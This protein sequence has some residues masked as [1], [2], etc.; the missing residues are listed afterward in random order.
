[1]ANRY[2]T[3]GAILDSINEWLAQQNFA[4]DVLLAFGTDSDQVM[5]N[6]SGS[7]GGDTALANVLIGTPVTPSIAA[8]TL[9]ISNTTASGD[10]LMAGNRGGN[11]EAFLF[12]DSN[13]GVLYL[14][15]VA[16]GLTVGLAADAPTAD[17][18]NVHLWNG[19]AGSVTANVNSVLV[20]E[21]SAE[22]AISMLG[23]NNEAKIIYFG[24]ASDND[25]AFIGYRGS[26]DTPANTLF[27]GTAASQ[28]LLY[29]ANA[30]AFQ[31][32]T[33]ISTTTGN[34]S[35]A[36]TGTLVANSVNA[37]V[38]ANTNSSQGDSP[39]TQFYTQISVCA[40]PG[41]AV[42][43]PSAATGMM[44]IVAN[45]GANSADIFPAT[46][47]DI[48]EAGVNVAY[49][50]AANANALFIAHDATNWSVILTA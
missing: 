48:N 26:T 43:L 47:D 1:M 22:V 16:G 2:L 31:E 3:P 29:S 4:D 10:I 32:A 49:A 24:E 38:T 30:F 8:N 33:T 25:I 46:G 7:L 18:S 45:D 37:G 19:T 28:R 27:F 13:N 40:N 50:L 17:N 12:Y 23:P 15:P 6:R 36:P 5:L 21:N 14:T 44:C 42:T 34:L 20:V 41:D 35:L 11:S 9:I 39:I